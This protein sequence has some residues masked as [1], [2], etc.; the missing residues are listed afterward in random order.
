MIFD[1]HM[2]SEFSFDS[3]MTAKEIIDKQIEKKIGICLTEHVDLDLPELPFIN[4]DEYLDFYA[5]YKS[6]DFLVGIE[7]GM[8]KVNA[9]KT[10]DFADSNKN[11]VDI[12]I[13]SIHTLYGKDIFYLMKEIDIEKNIVYKDYLENMLFCVKHFDFFDTLAHIDYICRYSTYTDTELYLEDFKDIIDEIFTVLIKKNKCLE[14]NTRRLNSK[15]A[16]NS[17]LALFK[18][19]KELGGKYVTIASDSHSKDAI[20]INFDIAIN[21][22]K[23]L[24]L[25]AVYFKNRIMTIIEEV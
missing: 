15:D 23:K 18:R 3:K 5:K 25:T 2:H 10:I 4:M 6:N 1:T 22:I 13:G 12:L 8:S 7:L 24:D 17:I 21:I 16:S 19:Y 9:N 11:K 20:A 14:L